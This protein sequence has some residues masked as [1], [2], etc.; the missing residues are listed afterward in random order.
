M[1]DRC[2]VVFT[3][4]TGDISPAIYSHWAGHDMP[5][6]LAEAGERGI[7]R[8]GD[9]S[10]AA[11][12]FCGHLH[13]QSVRTTGLG[14]LPP[15]ENLSDDVLQEYSHGDAGIAIVNVDTGSVR[16]AAGYLAFAADEDGAVTSIKLAP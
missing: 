13:E 15:P 7:L 1:G 2:L 9:A 3:D 16:Y 10:Y 11:A 14:L 6:L 4:D 8:E 5:A 12:R